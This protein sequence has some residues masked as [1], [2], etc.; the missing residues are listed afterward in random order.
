MGSDQERFAGTE[1]ETYKN[2]G[3]DYINVPLSCK[4]SPPNHQN[5]V[6]PH[7]GMVVVNK[8]PLSAPPTKFFKRK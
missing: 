1:A 5:P 8:I 3:R 4:S 6:T 7:L 2:Y